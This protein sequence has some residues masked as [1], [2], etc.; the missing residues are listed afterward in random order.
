[1]R[2][3]IAEDTDFRARLVGYLTD[4]EEFISSDKETSRELF[5]KI[6]SQILQALDYESQCIPPTSEYGEHDKR[7]K[8]R[9]EEERRSDPRFMRTR[10]G[11]QEDA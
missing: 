7:D 9:A 11:W 2:F 10:D 5:L 1:M 6:Q 3:Q 8:K 4:C